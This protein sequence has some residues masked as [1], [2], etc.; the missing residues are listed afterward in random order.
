MR[1]TTIPTTHA[2]VNV[3]DEKGHLANFLARGVT[4]TDASKIKLE[5]VIRKTPKLLAT[6]TFGADEFQD[7]R[8]YFQANDAVGLRSYVDAMAILKKNEIDRTLAYMISGTINGEIVN[9]DDTSEVYFDMF[10]MFDRAGLGKQT[11]TF[12]LVPTNF[13]ESLL[14]K[15]MAWKKNLI[16]LHLGKT[17]FTRFICLVGSE[18]KSGIYSSEFLQRYL[19]RNEP[20]LFARGIVDV[21]AQ[22][23][24]SDAWITKF[25]GTEYYDASALMIQTKSGIQQLVGDKDV[26]FIGVT[27]EGMGVM[28][29]LSDRVD[30]QAPSKIFT[31]YTEDNIDR[32]WAKLDMT[33]FPFPYNAF[34]TA[35]IHATG[36]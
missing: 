5:A 4:V 9:P 8:Y 21:N 16:A 30:N 2:R 7:I 26:K 31:H 20:Q 12:K 1:E 29:G 32:L 25:D 6:V 15:A 14:N 24:V 34:P 13:N 28:F 18:A 22:A 19:S 33:S 27:P 23:T 3:H 35:T 17:S 11:G 10:D 36:V